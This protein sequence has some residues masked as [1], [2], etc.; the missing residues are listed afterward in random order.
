LDCGAPRG[1]S[2]YFKFENMWLKFDGFVDQVKTWW[3]SYEFY[4]LPC[5]ILANKLKALKEDLKKWNEEVLGDVGKKKN[6]ILEGI[7]ELDLMNSV[8][9]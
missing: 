6:E 2:K 1:G 3:I 5:Y 7:R 4:G 9:A 8:V